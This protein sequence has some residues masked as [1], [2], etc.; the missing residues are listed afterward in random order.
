MLE[1][2]A[3]RELLEGRLNRPPFCS[4]HCCWVSFHIANI[5][6]KGP[7]NGN[8]CRYQADVVKQTAGAD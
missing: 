1:I 4:T 8:V 6:L 2:S 5:S 7:G 3:F